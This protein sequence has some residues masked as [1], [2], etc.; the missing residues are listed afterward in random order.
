MQRIWILSE[1]FYPDETSTSFILTKIANHMAK[2]ARVQVITA[3][4]DNAQPSASFSLNPLIK[5]KRVQKWLENKNNLLIRF[6]NFIHIS[7]ALTYIL[8]KK[9]KKNAK[10]FIVTNPVPLILL[11]TMLKKI[12][13][14]K[15]YVLVHDVFPENTISAGIIKK[16]TGISYRLMSKAFTWAYLQTDKIIVLG[17]DMREVFI[18]KSSQLTDKLIII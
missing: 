15:L 17:R 12:T 4:T 13:P 10:V 18:K 14:F 8:A 16:R 7:I 1:L 3:S 6:I 11:V 5:V 2:K 9:V